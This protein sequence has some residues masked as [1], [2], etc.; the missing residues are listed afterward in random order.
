MPTGLGLGLFASFAWGI[1]DVGAAVSTR[2][3]GSLR[4]LVGSQLVSLAV[5]VG[6]A[7]LMPG[8]LG[9]T[10]VQGMVLAFPLG[11]LA[12]AAYLAYFT[13]LRLGPLSIVSPV[14][15]AYGGATVVLAVVF[16]GETLTTMQAAGAV[17]ATS[18][19]VLAGVT[20]EAGSLRGMRIVGPGVIAAVLTLVGFAVLTL[21]LAVPIRE[22]G[23]LPAVIGSRIG[24]NLG[25]IVLLVVALRSGP[26][27][28]G[29]LLE[30][31][32]GWS[33]M[34][35]TATVATGLFDVVAF[36]AYAIGLSVAPV[37]LVG[38][39]SS[40]GPVLAVGY[41]IWRLGE[42]PHRTQW[43]GLALIALGVVVL[44]VSG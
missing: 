34:A 36:V 4:V 7:V 17:L 44:A 31:M 25:S 29:P 19:V 37:W 32:A 18:G 40:F 3:V 42:R 22:Y 11:L 20:F 16:R 21:L 38:L 43:A 23:W 10:P 9:P 35:V 24:N 33:R 30:P 12:A 26:G 1:V 28:F 6:I 27:R 14:I 39:A 8:L 41:A 13:A 5:L 2:L 15:V